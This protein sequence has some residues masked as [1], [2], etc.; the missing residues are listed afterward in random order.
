[1]TK[2]IEKVSWSVEAYMYLGVTSEVEAR[3]SIVGN[4][5]P[6]MDAQQ[7]FKSKFNAPIN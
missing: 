3:L 5:A 6:A 2:G 4:S 7:V 1:M